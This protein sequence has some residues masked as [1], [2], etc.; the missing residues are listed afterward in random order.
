VIDDYGYL[1]ARVRGMSTRLLSGEMFPALMETR[2][3]ESFAARLSEAPNYRREM[4]RERADA[5]GLDINA[6]EAALLA[7]YA[8]DVQKVQHISAGPPRALV[9]LFLSRYDL[10]NVRTLV[11]GLMRGRPAEETRRGILPLGTFTPGD[12]D[13]LSASGDL[14]TLAGTL[15]TWGMPFGDVLHDLLRRFSGEDDLLPFDRG[16]DGAWFPWAVGRAREISGGADLADSL[17]AE[18]DLR[19]IVT[20]LKL[21]RQ[22]TPPSQ[23]LGFVIAGGA[24]GERFLASIAESPDLRTALDLI[25]RTRYGEALAGIDLATAANVSDVERQVERLMVRNFTRLFRKDPL[26]FPTMLGYL[27]RRHAE[28]TDLRLIARGHAFGLPATEVRAQMV[29]A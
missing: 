15:L 10:H 12:L 19:N 28:F 22:S 8:E 25:G 11:R 4:E 6:M 16:L 9:D 5:G 20:L 2:D 26:G 3:L 27:W 1:N 14:S 29:N 17:S 7:A 24:V 18:V 13:E 23:A 21:V